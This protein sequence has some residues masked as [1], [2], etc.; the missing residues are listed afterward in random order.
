LIGGAELD[1]NARVVASIERGS[2]LLR[3]APKGFMVYSGDD[4]SGLALMLLAAKGSFR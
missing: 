4:A 1:H 2:D 3:R